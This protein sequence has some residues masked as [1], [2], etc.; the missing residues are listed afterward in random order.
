MIGKLRSHR[1]ASVPVTINQEVQQ[2][3]K[4]FLQLQTGGRGVGEEGRE[5]CR[6]RNLKKTIKP[7]GK[8]EKSPERFIKE[9]T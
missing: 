1:E 8:L 5:Q 6:G 2:G 9:K 7:E 4:R 3:K